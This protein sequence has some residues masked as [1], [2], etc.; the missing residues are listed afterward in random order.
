MAGA[1]TAA[2]WGLVGCVPG[3]WVEWTRA[4][5]KP[6][7]GCRR[8]MAG[9]CRR[10][11]GFGSA[12]QGLRVKTGWPAS[13]SGMGAARGGTRPSGRGPRQPG[14]PVGP[15]RRRAAAASP[16]PRPLRPARQFRLDVSATCAAGA[17]GGH[18]HVLDYATTHA[19]R[20][21]GRTAAAAAAAGRLDSL[22]CA[23]AN[24]CPTDARA[25]AAAAGGGHLAALQ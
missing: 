18:L 17:G 4:A 24:G 7:G 19:A 10:C 25:A 23:V 2:G 11:S 1:G 5:C 20:M 9:D 6:R 16:L 8:E 15:P 3:R 22:Q 14:V 21:D 12:A 13:L